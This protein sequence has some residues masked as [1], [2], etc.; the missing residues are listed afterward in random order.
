MLGLQNP[1]AG[2]AIEQTGIRYIS[3]KNKK[4]W[5]VRKKRYLPLPSGLIV[6]NQVADREALL[7]TVK[8]WVKV[9]RLRGKR[10]SLSIPHRRSSSV[11]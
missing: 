3:F 9:E 6:E 8:Q 2:L 10:I 4:S 7:E 5:E 1:V 11:K